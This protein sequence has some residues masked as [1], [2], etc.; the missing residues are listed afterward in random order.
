MLFRLRM[1]SFDAASGGCATFAATI[2]YCHHHI[3]YPPNQKGQADTP[4]RLE[5]SLM[6][7]KETWEVKKCV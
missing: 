2:I 1:R 6:F 7:G 3:S 4:L 5:D